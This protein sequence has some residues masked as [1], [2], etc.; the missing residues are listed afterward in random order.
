MGTRKQREKQEDIWIAHTELASAPG[1]PFYQRLNELLEAEGFDEFVEGRCAEFYAAKYGRPSL[2]PGIYFRSLLIGYF[3]GI[4]SER[5][6]AWRLADSLALRRFVGIA[7]DEYTP[8][9]S[10]ISR[11]R[12]LIDVETHQEVFGWVLGLLA[13]RGLVKG[14]RVAIDATTLEANAAMRAIVRRDTGE[15]YEEFLCGLAKASGIETPT[16]EDLARLD[17]KRK[18]R[19]SNEDWKS[20]ADGDARIAKMKDGRTHLAHK[21]EHAVDLDTG[22]VLA[23]TLQG[24]DQGDTTTLDETLSE[25]GIAVAELVGRE[26]ELRPDQQPKVNVNGIEELVADK[27]YHSGAVV[28]RV[29]SY[30]VRSYLPEKRQKGRRNWQGKAEQQQAVYQNRRRVRGRYGKSLLRR[31]GELVERSFAHCYD[32]G[33]MRRTHLRGHENIWKRQLVHVGAFNLSLILRQLRGAGTPREW[34]NR[35]GVLLVV[36]YFLRTRQQ[37]RNPLCRNRNSMRRA[38]SLAGPRSRTCRWPCQNQLFAPQAARGRDPDIRQPTSHFNPPLVLRP[39]DYVT[40]LV[41]GLLAGELPLD[42][43]A[44]AIH[45]TIPGPSLLAQ[46]SDVSDSAFA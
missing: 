28:E 3:E 20:P 12:R 22:A 2:T 14:Q 29:K 9:H 37:A 23:V 26:A 1:H 19:M 38:K 40:K 8:D 24:A 11:T 27:G 10:T 6:I 32:T 46:A 43:N 30:E 13:D 18:K 25:A 45:T 15:S 21:A 44:V 4:D 17:R 34:R 5:G 41:A 31:R 16:R 36:V 39:I 33:G 42:G 7:L 35:C